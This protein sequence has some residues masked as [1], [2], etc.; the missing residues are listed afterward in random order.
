MLLMGCPLALAL[1]DDRFEW[2]V[3]WM[4]L[5]AGR[6]E[7]TFRRID[8]DWE[9][10]VRAK[11]AAWL[12]RL[13]PIDDLLLTRWSGAPRWSRTEF[14]EGR[15][16]QRSTAIYGALG[17]EVEREQFV[18]GAW[19]DRSFRRDAPA[20]V[21][22]AL[23]ALQVLRESPLDRELTFPVFTG[24]RVAPLVA[25]PAR[26][27][28]ALRVDVSTVDGADVRGI[29]TVWLSDDAVRAPLR[30]RVE[31]RAGAVW[32]RLVTAD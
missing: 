16:R 22:D 29:M 6:A 23:G 21:Q 5:E 9:I 8:A 7:A 19:V 3:S 25:R 28:G 32:A 20:G 15:F 12:A 27:E 31:T 17:I 26:E 10:E 30:A 14:A 18:D 24:S 2:S 11:S 1:T 13:Y 4:G